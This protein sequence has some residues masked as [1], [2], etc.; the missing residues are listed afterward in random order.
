MQ[1]SVSAIKPVLGSQNY[2]S[3]VA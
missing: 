3:I 1:G 2:H